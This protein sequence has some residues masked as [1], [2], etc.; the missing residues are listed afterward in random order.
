MKDLNA[1]IG[2]LKDMGMDGMEVVYP[3]CQEGSREF[4]TLEVE[5][6][7]VLMLREFALILWIAGNHR[8]RRSS[9]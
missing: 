2:H 8:Q 4:P 6:L 5:K 3:Y 1:M 7:A 9:D